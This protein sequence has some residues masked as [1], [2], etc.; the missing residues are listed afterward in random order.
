MEILLG[1]KMVVSA[2]RIVHVRSSAGFYG[3]ESVIASLAAAQERLGHTVLVISLHA[4]TELEDPL[5]RALTSQGLHAIALSVNGRVDLSLMGRLASAFRD[6]KADIVH[7]HGY[8]EDLYGLPAAR[9]AGVPAVATN[10]LWNGSDRMVRLYER[11]DALVLRTLAPRIVAVSGGIRDEMM[12]RG[13]SEERI[14][15]IPNAVPYSFLEDVD[16]VKSSQPG[17]EITGELDE[18]VVA[19]C[20]RLAPEKGHQYMLDALS[21]LA[22]RGVR[23]V[24]WR[25]VGDGPLRSWLEHEIRSRAL[26]DCVMLDGYRSDV[27]SILA[28]VDAVVQPSLKEGMPIALLEAMALGVPVIATAV[29]A[30]PEFVRDGVSGILIAPADPISLADA[31]QRFQTDPKFRKQVGAAARADVRSRFTPEVMALQYEAVYTQ[32]LCS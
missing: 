21:L 18:F 8:K 16:G 13:V 10:H 31:L 28:A 17:R 19:T 32:V 29:G 12:A 27:R 11:L 23:S 6:F 20:A 7:L 5:V 2:M 26:D 25:V 3:A 30:V 9:R 1:P 14:S 22:S 4:G 24:H 15:V